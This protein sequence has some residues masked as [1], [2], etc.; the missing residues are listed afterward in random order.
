MSAYK[1]QFFSAVTSIA[2]NDLIIW[3]VSNEFIKAE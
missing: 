2:W 3:E 1:Y